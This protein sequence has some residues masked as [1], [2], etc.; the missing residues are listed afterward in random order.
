VIAADSAGRPSPQRVALEPGDV[1]V[2][3]V[4]VDEAMP[5]ADLGAA[6]LSPD[7]LEREARFVFERDRRLYRSAHVMV[8]S[9][10]SRYA[11]VSPADWR[12]DAEPGGKPRILGSYA[13]SLRFNLSHTRELAAVA[14]TVDDEVGVDVE[15]IGP[16]SDPGLARVCFT[17]EERR[18]LGD[19]PD[20]GRFFE[21]WTLKEAYLKARGQGLA[22]PLQ[23][24]SVRVHGPHA[25]SIAFGSTSDAT[26][27]D[28]DPEVWQF[29][30]ESL[31]PGHALAVA[32]RRPR[33]QPMR[34]TIGEWQP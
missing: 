14:V 6:T 15:R 12:F 20:P 13:P 26:R 32:L 23:G 17:S 5:V 7:E 22:L 18:G 1:H 19:P 9:V 10:L 34:V 11:A 31:P 25:A 30:R 4:R 2:A 8:R 3:Y 27:I 16:L 24:F 28:D 33:T 29:H 21:L